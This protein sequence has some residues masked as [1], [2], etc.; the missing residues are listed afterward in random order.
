M[1]V[2]ALDTSGHA[3][4]LTSE[5][6]HGAVFY[7]HKGVKRPFAAHRSIWIGGFRGGR[8]RGGLRV[9][10]G[11]LGLLWR[12]LRTRAGGLGHFQ[13]ASLLLVGPAFEV[14]G[15]RLRGPPPSTIGGR[16]GGRGHPEQ[17]IFLIILRYHKGIPAGWWGEG[18]AASEATTDSNV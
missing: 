11:G 15:G 8:G 6:K 4:T 12:A 17:L 14:R 18:K 5:C 2:P 13:N 1:S 10:L 3:L 9:K 16:R 7:L